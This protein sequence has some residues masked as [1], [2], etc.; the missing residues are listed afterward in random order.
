MSCTARLR[1][2]VPLSARTTLLRLRVDGTCL[3]CFR[4]GQHVR[5]A[6]PDQSESERYQGA[7]SIASSPQTFLENGEFEILVKRAARF[8]PTLQLLAMVDNFMSSQLAQTERI[9]DANDILCRF[10]GA[11]L[12]IPREFDAETEFL[13][14]VGAG[15][16]KAVA[17]CSARDESEAVCADDFREAVSEQNQRFSYEAWI[18]GDSIAPES[19]VEKILYAQRLHGGRIPRVFMCG[20]PEMQLAL[21][22]VL[23]ERFGVDK[24]SYN[25]V[26]CR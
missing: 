9:C 23:R 16:A 1:S 20:P 4:A 7:F 17:F 22:P 25:C 8:R 11:D 21:M 18:S 10:E 13:A 6:L 14:L 3:S 5:F 24:V 15:V 26:F 12:C 2:V 19:V